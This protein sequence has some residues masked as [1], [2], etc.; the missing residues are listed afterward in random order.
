LTDG[1]MDILT[2]RLRVRPLAD[3]DLDDLVALHLDPVVM[4]GSSG[5]ATP[6]TRA[7][8]EEW[9]RRTLTLPDGDG[10]GAFRLEERDTGAFVGRCGLRPEEGS[11][12]TEIA[13]ALV[14]HAWGQGLA[15]EAATAVVQHGF[16]AGLTRI[17][18]CALAEN[19][20]SL[21]VLEKV[22]MRRVRE[23]TTPVG[24]LVRFEMNRADLPSHVLQAASGEAPERFPHRSGR[25]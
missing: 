8:S 3:S 13:Y 24:W 2:S 6:R 15:T 12:D 22:G 20:A 14:R 17:V 25:Q 5:V 4:L 21:R 7:M 18:A 19:P 11:G 9:L 23:E 1:G 10:V 16:D